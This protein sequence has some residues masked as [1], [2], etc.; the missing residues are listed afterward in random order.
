MFAV[1]SAWEDVGAGDVLHAGLFEV[2]ASHS[3]QKTLVLYTVF[4]SYHMPS[5]SR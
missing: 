3:L 5:S 2:K 4:Y 1:E